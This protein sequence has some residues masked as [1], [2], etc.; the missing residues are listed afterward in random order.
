M[1]KQ[2][3]IQRAKKREALIMRYAKKR[4]L[5]QKQLKATKTFS[6]KGALYKRLRRIP[7]NSAAT[8]RRNRCWVT[9]RSR[10]FYNDFG[11]SRHVIRE[12][13][14]EGT[15]PGLTKSSW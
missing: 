13:M 1:A 14:G 7:K 5:L 10:G 9:G 4:A 8:R 12:F 11:L 15:I 3:I 6:E 2:S